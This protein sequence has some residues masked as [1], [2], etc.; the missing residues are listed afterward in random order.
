MEA[1]VNASERR[2]SKADIPRAERP[3]RLGSL[4]FTLVEPRPGM[5]AAYNRWYERDHFYSGCMIGASTLA[6]GRYVAT[7]ACKALRFGAGSAIDPATGSYL[8]LYW[9]LDGEHDNWNGW[10]VQQ[11]NA[12]HAE[13][14]MF[15]ERDHIHTGLYRYEAEFNADGSTMPIELALDRHYAGVVAV[16]IDL[17]PGKTADDAAAFLA[18]RP[19]PGD[20][21]LLA[22]PLPLS[23]TRP[24]D[25]P[26]SAGRH[27]VFV[28][29]SIE[30]PLQVWA[31]RYA[32]LDAAVQAAGLGEV[33]FAS[34]FLTTVFGT[35]TYA[36]DI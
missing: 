35:D 7:R 36:D 2:Y 19:C 24:A 25:V 4:L 23:A 20:V 15:T 31:E 11:V 14:R 18:K 34:P 27:C 13:E 22:S 5:A 32:P 6:G 12:L 30:D 29:F 1:D 28:S 9:I 33:S 26:D 8:A 16:L 21:A 17:A 3:V 10:G